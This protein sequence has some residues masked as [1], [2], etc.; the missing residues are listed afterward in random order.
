[1][2]ETTVRNEYTKVRNQTVKLDVYEEIQGEYI[3][4]KEGEYIELILSIRGRNMT[5]RYH[6]DS[7]EGKILK[8]E[9]RDIERGSKIGI[10]QTD[11]NERPICIRDV[12]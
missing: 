4:L 3:E 5:L 2:S 6:S 7:K 12:K 10:L 1:M 9:L 8:D 11:L